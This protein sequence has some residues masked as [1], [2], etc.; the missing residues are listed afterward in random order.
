MKNALLVLNGLLLVAVAFLFYKAYSKPG[1]AV[2]PAVANKPANPVAAG[3]LRIGYVEMD[4]L[5]NYPYA[6]EVRE[7]LRQRETQNAK[8]LNKIR[9]EYMALVNE[10]Q[11]KAQKGL[12]QQEEGEYKQKLEQKE[13]QYRNETQNRELQ[14]RNE[15]ASSNQ[16]LRGKIKGI[17]KTY[18]EQNQYDL[19]YATEDMD[20]IFYKNK[21]MDITADIVKYLNEDYQKN[22]KK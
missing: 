2:Q 9:D 3:S 6:K 5:D 22:K 13:N 14:M 12:S 16:D 7:H 10:Y 21:G 11:Q 4:S 19:I 20:N 8:E 1:D 17:L 15:M 18:A